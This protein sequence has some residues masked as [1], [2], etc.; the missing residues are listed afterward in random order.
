MINSLTEAILNA[1]KNSPDSKGV[2][3][4]PWK[5]RYSAT[6]A[7]FYNDFVEER[8]PDPAIVIEWHNLLVK[9]AAREDAIFPI[10]AGNV[11]QKLRRGWL[12]KAD[13]GFSYMFTDNDLAAYI[14]KMALDG[15]CPDEDEFYKFMTEFVAPDKIEWLT[16]INQNPRKRSKATI[17][18]AIDKAT[19]K[20][21]HFLRMPIHFNRIGGPG[22]DKSEDEKN[23]YINTTPAPTCCLGKYNY[24]HAHL[25]GVG[26]ASYEIPV[27]GIMTTFLFEDIKSVLLGDD[28]DY[29]WD[30]MISNYVWN[31]KIADYS[32]SIDFAIVEEMIKAQF[33]RFLDPLN[34]FLAPMAEQ[35]KFTK[36]NSYPALDIAEYSNLLRYI[37]AR[38]SQ[39]FGVAFLE[40]K[41]RVS[42]PDV[43]FLADYCIV[44]QETVDVVYHE[45]SLSEQLYG[46]GVRPPKTIRTPRISKTAKRTKIK[47]SSSGKKHATST[48]TIDLSKISQSYL[49]QFKPGVIAFQVLGA[50]L[51]S[52]RVSL[53][54][55]AKFKSATETK[56]IFGFE[57]PLLSPSIIRANGNS[58]CYVK[59][60]VL[61]GETLYMYS[62]W[63]DTH[64]KRLIQWILN[65]LSANGGKI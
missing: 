53:S 24:K 30:D 33:F 56:A 63:Y 59:P 29:Q 15:F 64:Q 47:V 8:L 34:H 39:T 48:E 1:D 49:E 31:R 20:E 5:K 32:G 16:I 13:D 62:Q 61:N 21:R 51:N 52:G 26:D 55:I 2:I 3:Y 28:S 36:F 27:H 35:N 23:A 9:Y 11:S 58:K 46:D 38:K 42:A 65:W 4:S 10:R 25:I 22:V 6:I 7:D 54:D 12:V 19:N 37:I 17:N 60:F 50:I 18:N 14:Y 43:L 57:K 44:G 41:R 45:K 40:F